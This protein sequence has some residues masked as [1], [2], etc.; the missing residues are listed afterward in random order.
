MITAL[1]CAVVPA[2]VCISLPLAASGV[3][4]YS[5]PIN[6]FSPLA[7]VK[8]KIGAVDISILEVESTRIA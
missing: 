1:R 5:N 6:T 8:A 3:I 4:V 7:H 2:S